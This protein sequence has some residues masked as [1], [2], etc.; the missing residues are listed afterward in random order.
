M[1]QVIERPALLVIVR[2]AESERNAAKKGNVYFPDE[3]SAACVKGVPDHETSITPKG[4][5]QAWITG[6]HICRRFGVFDVV[7]DSGYLRTEQTRN[8]IL[9]AYTSQELAEMK[10]RISDSIRE[11]DTGYTYDM[12]TEEA[13]R[14]FPWIK[15]Y[16]KEF[17]YFYAR[18]PGGES[19]SDVCERVYRFIGNLFSVRAGKKVLV[20]THG[21]T[22]RAFRYNLEKWTGKT[23]VEKLEEASLKNCGLIVYRYNPDTG[24]LELQEHGTTFWKEKGQ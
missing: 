1:A 4:V 12:T 6:R 15:E 20:V 9:K 24:R 2:H 21:G 22:A 17:G 23:Y 3:E 7:Y 11:R 10:L 16:F 14:H 13:H 5:M 19:Q 8:E 18:P